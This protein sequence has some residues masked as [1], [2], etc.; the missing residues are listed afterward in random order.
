[1]T[2]KR[3]DT[4]TAAAVDI[5]EAAR[6]EVLADLPLVPEH[7][8]QTPAVIWANADVLTQAIASLERN[9]RA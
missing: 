5:L 7:D 3:T 6:A 9:A 4:A 8:E 2:K 1:M